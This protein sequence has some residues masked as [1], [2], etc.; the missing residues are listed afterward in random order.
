MSHQ[1]RQQRP[2][3]YAKSIDQHI[4]PLQRIAVRNVFHIFDRQSKQQSAEEKENASAK[5]VGNS[6]NPKADYAKSEQMS[7]GMVSPMS[8][9]EIFVVA[10]K[11]R[12]DRD[13][14]NYRRCEGDRDR[15]LPASSVRWLWFFIGSHKLIL[16]FPALIAAY[17]DGQPLRGSRPCPA[18]WPSPQPSSQSGAGRRCSQKLRSGSSCLLLR[19]AAAERAS[20]P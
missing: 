20:Y 3:K 19:S 16:A 5:G 4:L 11:K 6:G 10:G 14:Q 1:N 7:P 8:V 12:D 9:Q 18:A 15:F 2:A 13:C 17:P